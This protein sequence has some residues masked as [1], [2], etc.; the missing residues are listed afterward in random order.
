MK[1]WK[2]NCLIWVALKVGSKG[3]G[4][5]KVGVSWDRRIVRNRNSISN[6]RIPRRICVKGV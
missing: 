2:V 3:C 4:L 5:C 6:K 1:E